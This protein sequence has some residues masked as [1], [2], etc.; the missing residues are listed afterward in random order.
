M[1]IFKGSRYTNVFQYE[2]TYKKKH[3]VAFHSRVLLSSFSQEGSTL[4]T[5]IQT[6]RLDNLAYEYY[7][8]PQYW[9]FILDANPRYMEEHHIQRGDVLFIPSMD[10]LRKITEES[11]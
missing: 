9:W 11:V 6:D 8:D 4:H 7:G 2:E 3:V 1:S 10:E 5:W